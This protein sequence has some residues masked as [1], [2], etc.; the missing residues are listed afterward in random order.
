[1]NKTRAGLTAIGA[2]APEQVLTN[3]DLEKMMDT[4]DE[5]IV[6]RTGIH[7]RHIAAEDEF[8][9]DLA[10][11]SVNDLVRRY[12]EQALEGVDLVIVAT[13]TPDAMLSS[14][15]ALLQALFCM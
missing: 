7:R 6:T 2:Y 15:A 13:Y 5:W 11:A 9:S 14:T 10:I 8:T 1:M 4:S 12:G 3:F